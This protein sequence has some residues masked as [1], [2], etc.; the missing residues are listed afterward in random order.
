MGKSIV[1][2][3]LRKN[4]S[5]GQ[6]AGYML[7]QLAGL[8][9]IL[10][11]LQFYLDVT[12]TR[13][14][15][16]S[17]VSKDY[18]VISKSVSGIGSLFGGADTRFSEKEID[19][20]SQQQWSS[21]VGRFT[22]SLYNV[23][24]SVNIGGQHLSTALF[25]ES[26]P[27]EYF[28]TM[29]DDWFFDPSQAE[30]PIV[31]SKDYLALYNYGFATSQGLPQL[32]EAMI[33][34]IPLQVAISGNGRRQIFNARI[35][36]FSSRLN[37]IAVPDSFMKW[38]NEKF[39]EQPQSQPSRLIVEVDNMES[40]EMEQYLEEHGYEIAG[41]RVGK[42][43]FAYLLKIVTAV[44]VLIGIIISALSFVILLLS[45]YLLLQKNR[46]KIHNLILLG[47]TPGNVA[48]YY[49]V[50]VGVINVVVFIMA[51]FIVV[52][53]RQG[54]TEPL[55]VLSVAP[56]SVWPSVCIGLG[57]ALFVTVSNVLAIKY[58]V[59]KCVKNAE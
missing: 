58:K 45:I 21:K 48:K 3:L 23:Y 28:D 20:I 6:L 9:I 24:A 47:Y 54:W 33:Q 39:A 44:V 59:G 29:P 22:A 13:E 15:E 17:Y 43:K 31:I 11:A 40:H 32:S 1:W 36:G 56:A 53:C 46:D 52:L 4:I 7:A 57:L 49:N 16:D 34:M 14:V 42:G 5:S 35:V 26:I 41:D 27:D 8:S 55:K 19:E 50:M 10:V 30:I 37:T 25:F 51:I 18:V 12:K 2:K 38:A